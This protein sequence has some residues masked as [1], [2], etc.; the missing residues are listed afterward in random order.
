MT[1]PTTD[2]VSAPVSLWRRVV[3]PAALVLCGVLI[4]LYPVVASNWNNVAQNKVAQ[5]YEELMNHED[6]EQL[7]AALE[8]ART[9]NAEKAEGPVLDPW[10]AHVNTDAPAYR[11]YLTQLAGRPAMSQ[12]VIPSID[13]RLPVYHGTKEET[14]QRGLGHLFGTALPVGGKSTHSVITGHT[15][16]TN[17]TLWDNLKNVKVGDAVYISTFG[18]RLKYQVYDIEI[19]T[20]DKTESLAKQEGR[21]LVTLITCTPYGINTHRILVHAERVPM[22]P[23]ESEVFTKPTFT[24][25]LWMR[26]VLAL[27]VAILAALVWWLVKT[28]RALR[29]ANSGTDT[30]EVSSS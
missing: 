12:V 11:E 28:V 7:N 27:A 8:A 4:M 16:I 3:L 22:D 30:Q 14:L 17:A 18:E 13:S 20:P 19:V 26:V 1:T 2:Q 25:Q 23:A 6:P 9:Y 24:M 29:R 10:L 5:E 15:G 21:D